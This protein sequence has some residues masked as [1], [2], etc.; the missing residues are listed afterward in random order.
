MTTFT[1]PDEV[2]AAALTKELKDADIADFNKF[3]EFVKEELPKDETLEE[4]AAAFKRIT[5]LERAGF[6]QP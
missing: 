6:K 2:L 4:F 3:I 5:L 1:V